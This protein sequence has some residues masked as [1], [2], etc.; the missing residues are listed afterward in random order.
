[1]ELRAGGC[2][3]LFSIKTTRENTPDFQARHNTAA[4]VHG[5]Q[6]GN[7]KQVSIPRVV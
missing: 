3:P 7:M 1:M 4:P 6:K 2:H 5:L